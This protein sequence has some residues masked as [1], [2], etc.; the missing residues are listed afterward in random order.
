MDSSGASALTEILSNADIFVLIFV[1]ILG[2]VIITP[3]IGG[4]HIP[5]MAR[6]GF[7]LALAGIVYY[8]GNTME[9]VYNDSVLGYGLLI[10]GEFFVGVI[11]GFVVFF[12][13]NVAYLA[14]HFIDQQIGFSMVSVYDPITQSQVP[15]TG[16]LYYFALC[17]LF[18]VSNGHHML[19]K[20]LFYSYNAIPVGAASIIGNGKIITVLFEIVVNFFTVGFLIALP[21]VGIILI[22]DVVLGILIKAVPQI[23]VFVVGMPAKVFIGLISIFIVLPMFVGIYNIIYSQI[24]TAVLNVIKVMM[25]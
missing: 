17:T 23:N 14:G 5:A 20:S 9:I 10:A 19:I 8:S 2:T 1:R 3:V 12:I 7:S 4:T 16:N 11:I 21:I 25:P 15:I 18:I 6:I 22:I 24:Y 13:L